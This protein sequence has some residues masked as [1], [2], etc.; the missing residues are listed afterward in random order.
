[1]DMGL[2]LNLGMKLEQKLT[3][4]LIQSLKILQAN[5]LE[6]EQMITEELQVNPLLEI[7]E[8]GQDYGDDTWE[9]SEIPEDR[10]DSDDSLRELK[11]EEN[12]DVDWDEY[13]KEGFD[14]GYHASDSFEYGEDTLERSPT[15]EKGL[16][17]YLL[18]QLADRKISASVRDIVEYLIDSLDEDGLLRVS[19]AIPTE[20]S[21]QTIALIESAI[22]K[23]KD[24]FE[25]PASVRDAFF[26]LWSMDPIGIGGRDLQECLLLQ[27]RKKGGSDLALRIL[28][29]AFPML[30]KLQISQ[31]VRSLESTPE[32][33]NAALKEISTLDPKPA[34]GLAPAAAPSILPDLTVEDDDG[35]LRITLNDKNMPVL[36]VSNAYK[37]I[38]ESKRTSKDDKNFLRKKLDGANF[39][40]RSIESRKNTIL[41]TMHAIVKRQREFFDEGP[42]ALKPMILQDIA[43]EIGMHISTVNRVTNGKYV[44]TRFGV[45]ELKQFFSSSV[46]QDSGEDASATQIREALRSLIEN[47]NPKAPL[48]DQALADALDKQGLN[49]ARRTVA[50]YREQMEFL[51]AR[52]RKKF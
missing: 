6:L 20:I 5:S 31:L 49:V 46:S 23:E 8:P 7:E 28:T 2:S 11:K 15:Y 38:Y 30:M 50:K 3:P 4:Q 25:Y 21:D 44:Q 29:D 16:R 35:S 52:L 47:E 13:F 45:F 40:I 17:E 37:D 22:L 19:E 34:K 27:F 26:V 10:P 36:R 33:I 42:S 12:G 48:S 32:E 18:E 9:D 43:D 51:P 24:L 39:L 1:M 41:K 14:L